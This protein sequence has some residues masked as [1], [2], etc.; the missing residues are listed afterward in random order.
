MDGWDQLGGS[1]PRSVIVGGVEIG[2]GSRVLLWPRSRGDIIDAAITGR[3]GVVESIEED[4]EGAV[5]LSVTVAD[6]PGRDLGRLRMPGHRFFF[7]LD[8]VEPLPPE[9]RDERSSRRL[10]VAGIGNVF[11]GDDGFGVEVVRRLAERPLPDEV[12]AI[13]FGIRG[14]DLAYALGE[15]DA[16][17]LV[18]A[19]P[20]GEAPGTLVVIEPDVEEAAATLDTHGM[21]PVKV[22]ALAR[23][24]G[25]TP[26]R[27]LVVA[28]E[29]A[30]LKDPAAGADE[31]VTVGLSEPVRR[32]VDSAVELVESLIPEMLA[33]TRKPT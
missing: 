9:A 5:H 8:E 1:A 3:T 17:I 12:Q 19:A 7:S 15:C 21:D 6:D 16:A 18:D 26:D 11:L 14:M 13:D 23:T 24:L 28:C 27:V 31:D 25:R 32:A 30:A 10:L 2:P 20:R 4:V 33:E 22:L 29:P